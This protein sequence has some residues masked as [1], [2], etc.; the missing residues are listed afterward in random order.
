MSVLLFGYLDFRWGCEGRCA[1][2]T[3]CAYATV[4]NVDGIILIAEEEEEEGA[5]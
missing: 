2:L 4:K 1:V 5:L 3:Y